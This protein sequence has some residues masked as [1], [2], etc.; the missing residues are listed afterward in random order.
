VHPGFAT[1]TVVDI[2]RLAGLS[3][4]TTHRLIQRSDFPAPV[5]PLRR[6]GKTYSRAAVVVWLAAW[7]SAKDAKQAAAAERATDRARRTASRRRSQAQRARHRRRDDLLRE[8]ERVLGFVTR[9][10][11]NGSWEWSGCRAVARGNAPQV[12]VRGRKECARRVLV[13][14]FFGLLPPGA[15]VRRCPTSP[16]CVNPDHVL[17]LDPPAPRHVRRVCAAVVVSEEPANPLAARG[18]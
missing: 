2:A 9:P 15:T 12:K 16:T 1:V 10:I 3:K 11:A 18:A 8:Q 13:E 7:R 4:K 5:G 17:V 14:M 6:Y